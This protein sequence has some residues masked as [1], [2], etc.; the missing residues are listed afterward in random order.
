LFIRLLNSRLPDFSH[1]TA[2]SFFVSAAS[3]GFSGVFSA[4]CYLFRHTGSTFRYIA[5]SQATLQM[6]RRQSLTRLHNFRP[7]IA[8]TPGNPGMKSSSLTCA[9][10]AQSRDF[11][12]TRK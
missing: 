10:G 9:D 8:I 7:N 11:R 1:K 6:V 5:G 2:I 4:G 12:S 3:F